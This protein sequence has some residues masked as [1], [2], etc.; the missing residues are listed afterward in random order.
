[1]SKHIGTTLS[2]RAVTVASFT[3][4]SSFLAERISSPADSERVTHYITI[5]IAVFLAEFFMSISRS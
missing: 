2:G 3:K 5:P 4:A 1:M